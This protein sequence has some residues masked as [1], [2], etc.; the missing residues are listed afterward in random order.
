[1]NFRYSDSHISKLAQISFNVMHRVFI[2]Y[3]STEPAISPSKP[4]NRLLKAD[5]YN[6]TTY[7]RAYLTIYK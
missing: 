1:M 3:T 7:I 6:G 5:C 4:I 2:G